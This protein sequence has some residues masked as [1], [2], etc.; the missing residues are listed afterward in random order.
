MGRGGGIFGRQN[1]LRP[2]RTNDLIYF[3]FLFT[4][5]S[6]AKVAV[7]SRTIL[8]SWS[9]LTKCVDSASFPHPPEA[10]DHPSQRGD[11]LLAFSLSGHPCNILD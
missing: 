8:L 4:S 5:I 11:Y 7:T 10:R 9:A 3:F 1:E 6:P 2:Q